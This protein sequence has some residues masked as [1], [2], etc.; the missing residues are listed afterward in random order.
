MKIEFAQAQIR[1]FAQAQLDSLHDIEIETIPGVKLGHKN[2]PVASVG[3]YIPGG[4]YP[5]V[6]S[7]HMSVLTARVAGDE[8]CNRM[9]TSKEW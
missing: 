1:N 3:C 2:M 8:T 6:A 7:A 5:M 4:R 9:H